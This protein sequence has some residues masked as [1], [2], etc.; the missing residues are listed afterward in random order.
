M[1][2]CSVGKTHIQWL[3][4]SHARI[5]GIFP[6]SIMRSGHMTNKCIYKVCSKNFKRAVVFPKTE[7]NNE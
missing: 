2:M 5:N 3:T 6:Y 7:M 4:M 1:C